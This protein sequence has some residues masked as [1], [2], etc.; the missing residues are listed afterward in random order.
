MNISIGRK[1]RPTPYGNDW[2]QETWQTA[3]EI[4]VRQ[5][6]QTAQGSVPDKDDTPSTRVER[7]ARG[8]TRRHDGPYKPPKARVGLAEAYDLAMAGL[9]SRLTI[10]R[11][12]KS[13]ANFAFVCEYDFLV[14]D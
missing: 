4:I 5:A 11:V 3:S 8:I 9:Q 7:R 1:F 13:A 2:A 10:T 6:E 14:E 12:D